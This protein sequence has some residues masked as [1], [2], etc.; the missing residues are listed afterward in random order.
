LEDVRSEFVLPKPA[1]LFIETTQL[2]WFGGI[3]KT[4]KHVQQCFE[5]SLGTSIMYVR[6]VTEHIAQRFLEPIRFRFEDSELMLIT[7]LFCQ[8]K[9][10]SDTEFERHVEARDARSRSAR[11]ADKRQIVDRIRTT[12]YQLEETLKT[13]LLRRNFK[14]ASRIEPQ[15]GQSGDERDVNEFVSG[16]ERD[17]QEDIPG[18]A[19]GQLLLAR[20]SGIFRA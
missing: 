17:V 12:S 6:V 19:L 16:C 11:Q 14:N 3:R 8:R 20:N 4:R 1:K 2:G 13:V 7:L 10:H 5:N 15:S 9:C 18:T